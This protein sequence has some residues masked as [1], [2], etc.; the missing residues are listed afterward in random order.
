MRLRVVDIPD[1]T[2]ATSQSIMNMVKAKD[3]ET[4]THCIRVSRGARLLAKAAG[5]GEFEQKIIEFAGLFH[6]IGKIAVPDSILL[7][8]ARLTD[9]EFAVMKT[10]PEKSVEILQPLAQVDF[11]RQLT[12]GVLYHHERFDGQ[13]YPHKIS[14]EKIPLEARVILIADTFDAM[15]AT[16]SYRKGLPKETAYKE[17]KDFGGRQFDPHLVKIFLQAH[18]TWNEREMKVFDEMNNTVLKIAA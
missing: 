1:W 4:Y 2:L 12:P 10:H 17:L 8:P 15:T 9:E 13:G 6:D 16:R 7:K 11:F 5:L 18:P 14:G 3:A